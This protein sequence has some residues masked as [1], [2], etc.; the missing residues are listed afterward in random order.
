[1][2][3]TA[4]IW[5]LLFRRVSHKKIMSVSVFTTEA[6]L[7]YSL[8]PGLEILREQT[9]CIEIL[10]FGIFFIRLFTVGS[11]PLGIETEGYGTFSTYWD[12][13]DRQ[14]THTALWTYGTRIFVSLETVL[15]IKSTTSIRATKFIKGIKKEWKIQR[16]HGMHIIATVMSFTAKAVAGKYYCSGAFKK[17]EQTRND[18]A[19]NIYLL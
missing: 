3:F 4:D 8:R 2:S 13:C 12:R 11:L 6:S 18:H 10:I 17:K 9:F 19:L 15:F 14:I 16:V 1:M 5:T 7:L